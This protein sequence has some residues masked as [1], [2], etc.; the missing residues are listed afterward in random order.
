M[1]QFHA[2]RPRQRYGGSAMQRQAYPV[3]H[4]SR[5]DYKAACRPVGYA[6]TEASAC[7]ILRTVFEG[8]SEAAILKVELAAVYIGRKA[9]WAYWRA[10]DLPV[11]DW[12]EE[13]A[14]S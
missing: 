10:A 4:C 11:T 2:P 6:E 13:R 9:M 8:S 14:R 1:W 5:R 7:K 12:P 3:F